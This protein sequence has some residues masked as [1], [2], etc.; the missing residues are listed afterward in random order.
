MGDGEWEMGEKYIGNRS[1]SMGNGSWG[2]GAGEWE[3]GSGSWGVG[4]GEWE[5]GSGSPQL[6]FHLHILVKSFIQSY[7]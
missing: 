7:V 3:L 6:A 5:L 4:A 2:M 1:W